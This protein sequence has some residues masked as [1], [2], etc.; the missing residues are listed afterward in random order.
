[1]TTVT[2]EYR[3][4]N[5]PRI[6]FVHLPSIGT[7]NYP[8][9]QTYCEEVDLEEYDTFLIFTATRFRT[10]YLDLAKKFKAIGKSFFLIRTRI[11]LDCRRAYRP[12][13]P[14]S[15]AEILELIRE[16]CMMYFEDLIST[17]KEIF[18]I[19]NYHTDKWDF[20]RLIE[21]ISA[22][23]P[24]VQRECLTLSL[25]NVTRNCLKRKAKILRGEKGQPTSQMCSLFLRYMV[26]SSLQF[27]MAD[28]P[29][30]FIVIAV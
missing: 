27:P 24:I 25:S 16:D 15:E 4:P 6:S 30:V 10:Y 22:A 11:D 21:A 3:H 23:L 2:A 18:L 12:R 7:P 19:S 28:T 29:R 20:D 1:M 8:D 5:N 14:V 13:E 17:E 26:L 9:L